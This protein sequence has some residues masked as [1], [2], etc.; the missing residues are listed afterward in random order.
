[1]AR[2]Q[3]RIE[4]GEDVVVGVNK[5]QPT[6]EPPI[7]VREVDNSRVRAQQLERLAELRSRRDG[8]RVERALAALSEAASGRGNLLELSIEAMRS[9]ATVGEVSAA[10]ERVFGRFQEN[11]RGVSG[12]YGRGLAGD[13]DF[14]AVRQRVAAFAGR[15]GRQPRVLVAKLGQDGHDR[16]SRLVAS[17]LADMGFDVDIGPL[18]Q[19][20]AEAARQAIENDAH[21]V[22]VSTMAAGHKTLVPELIAELR[23]RSASEILVVVGGVVPPADHGFLRDAG[24]AAVF[25]PGTRLTAAAAEIMTRLE[26]LPTV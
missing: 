13:A 8:A 18:F 21:L 16:G 11:A 15:A 10:L 5:Y 25:G 26:Q 3:A 19:T 17:A 12:V 6:S 1:A 2:K 14:E 23:Q 20:P 7:E 9:R 24:V 4:R 22:G